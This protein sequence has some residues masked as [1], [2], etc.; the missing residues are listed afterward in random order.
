LFKDV[1]VTIFDTLGIVFGNVKTRS[2]HV[3]KRA[4][5][6]NLSVHLVGKILA[7]EVPNHGHGVEGGSEFDE[8][9]YLVFGSGKQTSSFH[10]LFVV[11]RD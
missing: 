9:R 5:T 8:E 4:H 11:S 3:L 7:E 6:S 10:D 1:V 2:S